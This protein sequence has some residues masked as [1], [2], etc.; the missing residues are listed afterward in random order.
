M[1]PAAQGRHCAA[2]SKVVVDFTCMTDAEVA[3]WLQ[4]HAG[5]TCGRFSAQQLNR[6]LRQLA[7]SASR[8]R[9]WL[10]AAATL[11]GLRELAAEKSS[12]QHITSIYSDFSTRD[13]RNAA[14]LRHNAK[15]AANM[16]ATVL[17]GRVEDQSTGQGLPGVTVLVKGTNT[18]IATAADG[19]FQLKIPSHL[20]NKQHK[21]AL[22]FSYIGYELQEIVAPLDGTLLTVAMA[23]N[24]CM[25]GEVVMSSVRK[26][27]PWHPR[28]LWN[29]IR[30]PFRR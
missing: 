11:L 26:P 13:E 8:W 2:C 5:S 15:P 9:T 7:A 25:L 14:P 27:W 1:T 12:A 21:L 28:A 6:P 18:G 3:A 10:A 29:A 4:G 16:A 24:C 20:I 19:T 22:T 23:A 17:Q 30:R